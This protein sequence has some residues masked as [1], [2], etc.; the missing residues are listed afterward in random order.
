VIELW[1]IV[2]F[3]NIIPMAYYSL[4]VFGRK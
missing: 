4:E 3:P 2:D 1:S